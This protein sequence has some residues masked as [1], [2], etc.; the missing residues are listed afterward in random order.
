[1]G[2]RRCYT[3]PITCATSGQTA[4]VVAAELC[5]KLQFVFLRALPISV[6]VTIVWASR[7]AS[8]TASRSSRAKR[9]DLLIHELCLMRQND[10]SSRRGAANSRFRFRLQNKFQGVAAWA[11]ARQFASASCLG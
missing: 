2:T 9:I 8:I 11:A 10:F 5:N 3:V 7:S 6:L 4:C 1:R